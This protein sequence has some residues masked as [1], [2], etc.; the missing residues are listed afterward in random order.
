MPRR[1]PFDEA[2]FGRGVRR[3]VSCVNV[4]GP[5]TEELAASDGGRAFAMS[6]FM[7]AMDEP[8]ATSA[9]NW[10]RSSFEKSERLYTG[11]ISGSVFVMPQWMYSK[12]PVQWQCLCHRWP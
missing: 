8:L 2:R 11:R 12:Y 5:C 9:K 7:T 1:A 3:T 4:N 6:G 10:P